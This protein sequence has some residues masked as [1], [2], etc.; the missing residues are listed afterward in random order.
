LFDFS[1]RLNLKRPQA[2][3]AADGAIPAASAP[4]GTAKGT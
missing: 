3:A 1:M 4:A 2:P